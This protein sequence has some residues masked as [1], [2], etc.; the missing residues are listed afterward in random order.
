MVPTQFRDSLNEFLIDAAND[1]FLKSAIYVSIACGS[2]EV[3]LY[4]LTGAYFRMRLA[5]N[6][7]EAR[8][9]I[10]CRTPSLSVKPDYLVQMRDLP[11]K[12][13]FAAEFKLLHEDGYANSRIQ[14]VAQRVRHDVDRLRTIA[15]ANPTVTTAFILFAHAN[16]VQLHNKVHQVLDGLSLDEVGVVPMWNPVASNDQKY[17]HVLMLSHEQI[18]KFGKP[19]EPE[20]A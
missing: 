11:E 19:L 7:P 8:L 9:A 4:T 6:V 14:E 12:P 13:I 10:N 1:Q 20:G 3:G 15:H 5:E 2:G 16:S 18:M 17:L